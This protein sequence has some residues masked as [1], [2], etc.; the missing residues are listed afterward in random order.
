MRSLIKSIPFEIGL[1]V[2][3][4]IFC[5]GILVFSTRVQDGATPDTVSVETTEDA[6]EESTRSET[7]AETVEGAQEPKQEDTPE[8]PSEATQEPEPTPTPEPTRQPIPTDPVDQNALESLINPS[9]DAEAEEKR[10]SKRAQQSKILNDQELL[11]EVLVGKDTDPII[12]DDPED[13]NLFVATNQVG[14]TCYSPL[15]FSETATKSYAD[16]ISAAADKLAE[17]DIRLFSVPCPTSVG[18]LNPYYLEQMHSTNPDII[19]KEIASKT[20]DT[21]I[22]VNVYKNLH[23]HQDEYLYYHTDHHW[24]G[25]A[26]YYAYQSFCAC[27]GFK[28]TSLSNY[29]VLDE[30]EFYGTYY[31]NAARNDLLTVDEMIAYRP[32]GDYRM[33]VQLSGGSQPQIYDNPIVDYSDRGQYG[34]YNTFILGDNG[35]VDIENLDLPDTAPSRAVIKDSYGNPFCVYLSQHYKHVY[36]LDYRHFKSPVAAFAESVPIDDV[37]ICQS[38]GVS[39]TLQ[40]QQILQERLK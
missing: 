5:L 10:S 19:L 37:I 7:E 16:M 25:L 2:L 34:K 14:D 40:A 26:A 17:M 30:G 27:A 38:M 24:T 39:Q 23:A 11:K 35:F 32:K 6:A 3:C 21:V 36:V 4:M 22:N 9:F 15:G 20:N 8:T 13:L 1:C 33:S 12:S 18:M 29:E 31:A 28:P